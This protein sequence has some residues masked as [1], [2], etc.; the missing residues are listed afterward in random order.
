MK[1]ATSLNNSLPKVIDF[2]PHDSAVP[3]LRI[4]P[5]EF[6]PHMPGNMNRKFIAVWFVIIENWDQP[7]HSSTV[8]GINCRI[9]WNT[10]QQE[11]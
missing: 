1:L 11:I 6:V 3:F 2:I 9:Q 10:K 8:E 4:Y 5:M 7:K